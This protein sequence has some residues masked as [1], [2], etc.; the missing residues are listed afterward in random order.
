VF[1]D[2]L[3][4]GEGSERKISLTDTTYENAATVRA[5][6]QL[7]L[8]GSIT[9]DKALPGVQGLVSFLDKWGC[10]RHL[11]SLMALVELAVR[12][13]DAHPLRAFVVAASGQNRKLCVLIIDLNKKTKWPQE[14]HGE[15]RNVRDEYGRA[16]RSIWDPTYWPAWIFKRGPPLNYMFAITRAYG[17]QR[18]VS[19][20]SHGIDNST[21]SEDFIKYLKVTK[22]A[23]HAIFHRHVKTLN[24]VSRTQ[25]D[26]QIISSDNVLF[27]VPS[28]L[29]K[30]SR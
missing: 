26:A 18:P 20:Y 13:G 30:A 29:L 24:D 7:I 11:A 10:E 4:V 12:R 25:G 9:N 8:G 3:G 23:A 6:L 15:T 21:L 27:L 2:A 14:K 5:F 28:Y 16:S 22:T 1:R 19:R 17:K